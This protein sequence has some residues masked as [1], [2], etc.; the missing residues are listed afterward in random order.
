MEERFLWA[1]GFLALGLVLGT[2]GGGGLKWL[3]GIPLMG[4]AFLMGA[5][6]DLNYQGGLFLLA[7]AAACWGW[8][9]M[10]EKDA[11][12]FGFLFIIAAAIVAWNLSGSPNLAPLGRVFEAFWEGL[13][14]FATGLVKR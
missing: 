4:G 11:R 13:K 9:L 12:I 1:I 8:F 2:K 3:A 7:L 5:A 10:K 6:M 14:T